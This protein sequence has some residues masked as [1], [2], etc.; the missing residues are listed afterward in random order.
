MLSS[1]PFRIR[2]LERTRDELAAWRDAT[3]INILRWAFTAPGGEPLTLALGDAWPFVDRQVRDGPVSLSAEAVIPASFAGHKVRLDLN[4]GG[5]GL[6]FALVDG[7]EVVSGGLNPFHREFELLEAARGGEKIELRV[8]VVPKGLFGSPTPRPALEAARL[9]A[10][11]ADVNE[12]WLDLRAVIDAARAL[13]EHEATPFILVAGEK[14]VA[15]LRWPSATHEYHS[16]LRDGSVSPGY[17]ADTWDVPTELPPPRPL[18]EDVLVSVRAARAALKA[19]LERARGLYPPVGKLGLSGHAHLDLGWLWPVAETHRKGRRTLRSVMSLMRRDPDFKFNQSSAQLYEW[20]EHEDPELFAEMKARVAEGR[21]E[22]VGGMWVEPDSNVPTGESLARQLLYGQRYFKE[23]FGKTCRVGWVPDSFGFSGALPQLL[24]QAGISGFFT[25]KMVWNEIT[26]FPYDLYWWEGIDGSRVLAH[27]LNN[28]GDGYNGVVAPQGLLATWRNFKGKAYPLWDETDP[29]SLF[30]VGKGDGGGGATLDDLDMFARL[31]DFPA[32]P[33]LAWTGVEEFWERFPRDGE[34]P[35]WVGEHYLEIHRGTLDTQARTK[36]LMRQAEL[37]LLEAE[38]A[39]TLA[40]NVGRAYPK[41]AL[42]TAWKTV[43]LNQFHD[44]LPGSSIREVYE[45]T[46][47][48]LQGVIDLALRERA[49]AVRGLAVAGAEP[50]EWV[51]VFNASL[52]ERPLTA[53]IPGGAGRVSA[54]DGREL[55]A[56]AAPG[57]LLVSDPSVS[58]PPLGLLAL[59]LEPNVAPG[60]PGASPLTVTE[61]SDGVTLEN[62]TLRA[63]IGADGLIASLL[64]KPSGREALSAPSGRLVAYRD[65]PRDWEAWDVNAGVEAPGE[66]IGGISSISVTRGALEATVRVERIWRGSRFT[67]TYALR[68]FSARLETRLQVSWHERRVMVRGVYHLAPKAQ[69]AAFEMAFGALERPT[70]RSSLV[71]AA[72]F[73]VAGHRWVDLSEPGFGVSLLNDGKYGF[74]TLGSTLAVTLLRGPLHPDY[75]A[76]EG[77]HEVTLALYPHEGGW[78][79]GG[80]VAEAWDLNS[81]LVVTAT[82]APVNRPAALTS[83]G[84]GVR[85]SAF[86]PAEDGPGVILR[87]YEPFGAHGM[88]RFTVPGLRGAKRVTILEEAQEGPLSVNGEQVELPVRPFEV[89]TLLLDY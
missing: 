86:K 22:P 66:D 87:V 46:E 70:H 50:G 57:G 36:R 67:Q 83:H 41:A 68:A 32:L 45:V 16:R 35:T 40:V 44:I 17:V 73:E 56:Q 23:K 88:A 52:D 63:V 19:G 10:V 34:I 64:H 11:E 8:Q 47:P 37:R 84:H 33:R 24:V 81:P 39:G 15:T 1:I 18:D 61:G 9:A 42:E 12:L 7:R 79:E 48:E 28:P 55:N 6:A 60:A 82:P 25:Q 13:G 5:E 85:L 77:E 59:R 3:S 78:A 21:L 31:N 71:D 89:V 14:A 20:L 2:A 65:L 38:V 53:F 75:L 49:E 4:L 29:Q 54:M 30:L 72:K 27:S 58:V 76:D 80:A 74:S 69:A 51:S 43:L 62:A 26:P